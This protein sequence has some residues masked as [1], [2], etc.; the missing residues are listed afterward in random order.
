MINENNFNEIIN[1]EYV[2]V[3]FYATWCGPCKMLGPV[4]EQVKNIEI[5]KLDVDECPNICKEY[6]IMSVPTL[7]I[8]NKGQIISKK[9]GY[10][11]LELLQ[12]WIDESVK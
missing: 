8:F 4:L 3:D 6:G 7:I 9:N 2:L 10:M 5:Y 12:S 11:P 1:K